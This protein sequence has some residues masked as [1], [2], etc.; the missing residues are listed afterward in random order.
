MIKPLPNLIY[1]FLLIIGISCNNQSKQPA[2]ETQQPQAETTK[3]E[4]SSDGFSKTLEGDISGKYPVS[5]QLIRK[6]KQL[7]GSY[8]YT[9]VGTAIPISGTMDENGNISL[10]EFDEKGNPT[11]VFEGTLTRDFNFTGSWHKPNNNKQL[12]FSLHEKGTPTASENLEAVAIIES[13]FSLKGPNE[14]E[15]DFSFPQVKEANTAVL[16]KI[17]EALAV[18]NLTDETIDDIKTNFAQCGCGT[19]GSSYEVNYNKNFLLNIRVFIETMGAYPS[20]YVN[21]YTFNTTTGEKLNINQLLKPS[22]LSKLAAKC[23]KIL[24]ERIAKTL[25]EQSG[26]E[27]TWAKELLEGKK[28]EVSHLNNFTVNAKGITF[29][30][31]FDFPHAALALQP[32]DDFPFSFTELS[33]D[34]APNGL[35]AEEIPK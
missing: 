11:G 32:D 3:Q 33:D 14:T 35:L 31:A 9:K 22:S 29:Y 20:G 12:P 10:Q 28:F 30:F 19:V 1:T 6:G 21:R 23:N 5:M 25:E 2:T 7:E 15:A 13:S 24:Q 34:I 18:K 4:P 17:N 8:M 16:K 27:G 26:E